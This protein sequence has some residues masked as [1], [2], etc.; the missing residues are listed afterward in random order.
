MTHTLSRT[1]RCCK[2]DI[3]QMLPRGRYG[4]AFAVRQEAG[5][6]STDVMLYRWNSM[7][8]TDGPQEPKRQPP[9]MRGCR[10]VTRAADA[11]RADQQAQ[12]LRGQ[13][14]RPSERRAS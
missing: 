9:Q 1:P 4:I 12:K 3:A 5:A 6:V 10:S 14:L 2:A 13:A 11:V 7:A 8:L